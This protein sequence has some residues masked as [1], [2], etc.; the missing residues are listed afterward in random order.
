MPTYPI[1][2]RYAETDQMGVVHHSAYVVWLE[3]ARVRYL[4]ELGLDYAEL[5]RRGVYFP[6]TELFLSYRR[7]LRFGQVARVEVELFEVKS[8]RVAFSYRVLTPEGELAAKGHTSHVPQDAAGRAV[9]LPGW[10]HERLLRALG[11]DS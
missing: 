2:V 8:R 10:V 9:R 6:V 1:R 5:E 4:E 11:G 7:P 3:E